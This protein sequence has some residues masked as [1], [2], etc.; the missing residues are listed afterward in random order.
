MNNIHG[1]VVT[2]VAQV[3]APP[4]P[5][6]NISAGGLLGTAP[7]INIGDADEPGKFTKMVD[8]VQATATAVTGTGTGDALLDVDFTITEG[9]R[10]YT[11]APT[12]MITGG[13]GNGAIGIAILDT[14]GA[15]TGITT[16]DTI[17][18][19]AAEG[20]D[21]ATAPTIE[22]AAPPKTLQA[23]Y[24]EPYLLLRRGDA[25]SDELGDEGTLP[26]ALDGLFAQQRSARVIIVPVEEFGDGNALDLTA[27]DKIDDTSTGWSAT[28]TD[29]EFRIKEINNQL[30]IE[31][32]E[33]ATYTGISGV[34]TN[35]EG[36][37][38]GQEITISLSGTTSRVYKVVG[39]PVSTATELYIPVELVT[40]GTALVDGSDYGLQTPAQVGSV[41]S[42]AS[43]T[44]ELD[45]RTGI[46]AMLS[47]K[48]RHGFAPRLLSAAGLDTGSRPGGNANPLG[49]AMQ[50]VAE[51]LRGIA[52]IDGPSTTHQAALD[53]AEDYGSDRIY[54]IDPKVKCAKDGVAINCATSAF[55]VGLTLRTD[56]QSGYWTIPSNKLFNNVLG[57][58]RDIDFEMGS[59]ASRAQ[60][61]NDAQIAT[62]VNIGGGYRLWGDFTRATGDRISWKFLNVRRLAD[63]LYDAVADNHLWAVD[64]NIT[65]NYLSTV[66]DGVNALLRDLTN[67]EA[68]TG[69]EC[70][71]DPDLNSERN[72]ALGSVHFIVNFTPVY[73]AR[74]VNFSIELDT[75]RLANLVAA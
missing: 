72:I 62:V 17:E 63:A 32:N 74:T 70:Y 75:K 43:A 20:V 30:S 13:G 68:I 37:G 55:A 50:T 26:D 47:A 12:V 53:S 65:K 45:D 11:E 27:Y 4:I 39:T 41:K 33:S 34:K 40:A 16:D 31:F 6:P 46:Y 23:G 14:S 36:L 3:S 42:R 58:E 49:A 60:L 8:G 7:G 71:P 10:G 44:G 64:K 35:I 15:V 22:I 67:L 9:G 18:D 21:Y 56:R 25:P 66:A 73:P 54:F 24:D 2:E 48:A 19:G 69:G 1:V 29:K 61:L 5:L 59:A 52:Y 38:I 51:E 57:T 28:L